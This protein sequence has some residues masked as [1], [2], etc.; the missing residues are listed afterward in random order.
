MWRGQ[1]VLF[2]LV[3]ESGYNVMVTL[4]NLSKLKRLHLYIKS[5]HLTNTQPDLVNAQMKLL[6]AIK[7]E[8]L[9]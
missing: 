1:T 2:T 3:G 6:A 9:S 4:L 8:S 5:L 7:S